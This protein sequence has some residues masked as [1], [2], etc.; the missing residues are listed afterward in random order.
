MRLVFGLKKWIIIYWFEIVLFSFSFL[1]RLYAYTQSSFA[2]GWDGYFYIIQIQSYVEEGI[3]HS[4]RLSLFYPLLLFFQFFIQNYEL[5]YQVV[6]AFLVGCFTLSIFYTSKALTPKS[7]MPYLVAALTLISPQ[8]TFFGAQYAKNLF[9]IVCFLWL[10]IFLLKAQYIKSGLFLLLNLFVHK[11]TAGLSI[12][13]TGLVILIKKLKLSQLKYLLLLALGCIFLICLFPTL[14]GLEDLARKGFSLS[15]T[16][17]WPSV[18]FIYDFKEVL[19]PWWYAEVVFV[20]L[21]FIASIGYMVVTKQYKTKWVVLLV[22]L[23]TLSFP[24]LEWS[25]VG[26]SFRALMVFLLLGIL[27][28]NMITI[29]LKRSYAIIIGCVVAISIFV[30]LN[31]YSPAKYDPPYA[32]YMHISDKIVELNVEPELIIVHKAFAEYFTFYTGIDALPWLPEYHINKAALW[33]IGTGLNSKSIE[34]FSGD[35]CDASLVYNLTP[36]YFLIREDLWQAIQVNLKSEDPDLYQELR[37]WKNPS[38][39][40]PAY[41]LKNKK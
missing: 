6:S 29:I 36:N 31:F 13:I 9:G 11:L 33:R 24:L 14:F 16:P 30:S 2:N 40:R 26:L 12:L 15:S 20:N 21:L 5:T 4:S 23:F 1:I 3:M 39:I 32:M 35:T 10:F 41:L 37:T 19:H 8:L 34:Y 25:I 38:E 17:S 7:D 22:L 18:S 27:L 28:L